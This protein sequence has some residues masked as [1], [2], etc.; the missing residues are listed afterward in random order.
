[1]K[2]KLS[3]RA[4]V[5]F[6]EGWHVDDPLSPFVDDEVISRAEVLDLI[7]GVEEDRAA[8]AALLTDWAELLAA[9]RL[10]VEVIGNTR[11]E[12]GLKLDAEA[13]YLAL[14]AAI[15]NADGR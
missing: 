7:A 3:L 9:A 12:F 6:L 13:A 4:Q 2:A 5:E 14:R 10:A 8:L 11:D 1:M 15:A